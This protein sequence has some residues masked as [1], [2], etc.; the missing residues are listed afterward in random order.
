MG[1]GLGVGRVGTQ[2]DPLILLLAL[3]PTLTGQSDHAPPPSAIQFCGPSS[4]VSCSVL[5]PMPRVSS[6]T[7]AHLQAFASTVS[8]V[9]KSGSSTRPKCY[10]LGKTKCNVTSLVTSW[11]T[12]LPP[13]LGAHSGASTAPGLCHDPGC[14]CLP[15]SLRLRT[16]EERGRCD[17][18][19][20]PQCVHS[21]SFQGCHQAG[22]AA[23]LLNE[24]MMGVSE[25]PGLGPGPASAHCLRDISGPQDPISEMGPWILREVPPCGH[26]GLP[27]GPRFPF[28]VVGGWVEGACDSLSPW[29]LPPL[30]ALPWALGLP[31]RVSPR[32]TLL[33]AVGGVGLRD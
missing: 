18:S 9:S 7:L 15:V 26:L 8:L 1:Q 31:A 5:W 27:P 10:S 22:V 30:P 23:S 29:L 16:R 24:L 32:A 21:V 20:G 6:H 25:S 13:G 33:M 17:F 19:V 3:P 12:C 4:L 14:H 2:G 28:I 11:T